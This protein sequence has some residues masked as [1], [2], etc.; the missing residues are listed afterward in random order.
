LQ[1]LRVAVRDEVEVKPYNPP[2][3]LPDLAMLYL[4]IANFADRPRQCELD[5]DDLIA[6]LI[7][8]FNGQASKSLL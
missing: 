2:K 4:D 5:A 7:R 3:S 1:I 6:R 8:V